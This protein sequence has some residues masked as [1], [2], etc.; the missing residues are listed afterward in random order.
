MKYHY[1]WLFPFLFFILGYYAVSWLVQVE[2]IGAPSVVGLSLQDALKTISAAQLQGQIIAEQEEDDLPSGLV[3][4]QNPH[5]GQRM[6]KSQSVYLT[7][8]KKPEPLRAPV[9]SGLMQKKIEERVRDLRIRI[10]Y[11]DIAS[12]Y[13]VNCC[14]AQYPVA[15]DVV[16]DRMIHAYISSGSTSLRIFPSCRGMKVSDVRE[17]LQNHDITAQ[18]FHASHM[19]ADHQCTN[20]LVRDQKPLAGTLFD[21]KKTLI[22]QLIVE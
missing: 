4:D 17:F 14:Y 13:P 22:V 15:G 16:E 20:C 12:N 5:A 8:A 18:I 6:K 21:L 10:K 3:L 1:L 7:V 19:S 2:S 11:H 9:L